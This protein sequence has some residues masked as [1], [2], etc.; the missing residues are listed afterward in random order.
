MRR[1]TPG[2]FALVAFAA[3][4]L[5]TPADAR[6]RG[7]KVSADGKKVLIEIANMVPCHQM[8]IRYRI[9]A[10][11]GEQLNQTIHHT[12]HEVNAKTPPGF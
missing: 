3:I 2:A 10:A 12:I 8:E 4:C 7:T 1:I 9:Q 6:R 11:D 5:A